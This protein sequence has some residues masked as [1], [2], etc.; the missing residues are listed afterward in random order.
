[1]LEFVSVIH[2]VDDTQAVCVVRDTL[3]R[4]F[5]IKLSNESKIASLPEP[6]RGHCRKRVRPNATAVQ[7][8]QDWP[9]ARQTSQAMVLY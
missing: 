9:A 5:V 2:S 3:G 7:F 6:Q 4:P 8:V 1:M